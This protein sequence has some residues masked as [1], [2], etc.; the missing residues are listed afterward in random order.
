MHTGRVDG[1]WCWSLAFV[2]FS[3]RHSTLHFTVSL[4]IPR[5]NTDIERCAFGEAAR[6]KAPYCRGIWGKGSNSLF[7]CCFIASSLTI[8][9]PG[10]LF[11][12]HMLSAGART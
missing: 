11:S 9:H 6:R 2:A 8:S 3:S 5:G 1:Q 12:M 7:S 4:K 10:A